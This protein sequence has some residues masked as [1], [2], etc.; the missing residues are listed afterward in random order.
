MEGDGLPWA[1]LVIIIELP[2]RRIGAFEVY[3]KVSGSLS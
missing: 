1:D 3:T 2:V